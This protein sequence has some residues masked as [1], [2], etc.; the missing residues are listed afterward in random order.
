M[1]TKNT[2]NQTIIRTYTGSKPLT[3]NVIRT[4]FDIEKYAKTNDEQLND[5]GIQLKRLLRN[6]Y[7]NVR[8]KNATDIE[9]Y[10]LIVSKSLYP[11]NEETVKN[12]YRYS[13][14]GDEPCI[15]DLKVNYKLT[16]NY[17]QAFKIKMMNECDKLINEAKV[18]QVKLTKME[19]KKIEDTIVVINKN[20]KD[21]KIETE[22]LNRISILPDEIIQLIGSFTLTNDMRLKLIKSK[23]DSILNNIMMKLNVQNLNKFMQQYVKLNNKLFIKI[24]KSTSGK[25]D[26]LMKEYNFSRYKCIIDYSAR[27]TTKIT[28]FITELEDKYKFIYLLQNMMNNKYKHTDNYLKEHLIHCYHTCIYI[29][30]K[31]IENSVKK[32]NV[33][34]QNKLTQQTSK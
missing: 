20:E 21:T 10:M 25:L 9:D 32:R 23:Y 27:K 13:E 19:N 11:T 33:R 14:K 34:K 4:V 29:S 16:E 18:K 24:S 12:I 1:T 26:D 30:N 17:L 15:N 22:Y 7:N 2:E 6:D 3:N 8:I 28:N 5:V 31:L